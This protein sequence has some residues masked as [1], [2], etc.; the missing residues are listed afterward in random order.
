M[1]KTTIAAFAIVAL[2]DGASVLRFSTYVLS[3]QRVLTH[4][5]NITCNTVSKGEISCD[6]NKNVD[7]TSSTNTSHDHTSRSKMGVVA[8]FVEDRE[9]LH[10][11]LATKSLTR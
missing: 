11:A 2:T 6:C 4:G 8:D 7:A 1:T 9:H 10:K 5:D 3:G